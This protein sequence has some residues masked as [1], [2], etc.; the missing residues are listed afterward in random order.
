MD[1][2][3]PDTTPLDE[4]HASERDRL[5]DELRGRR[6]QRRVQQGDD[7][8]L[9]VQADLSKALP[10]PTPI[11]ADLMTRLLGV[12]GA[13]DIASRELGIPYVVHRDSVPEFTTVFGWTFTNVE[14]SCRRRASGP[15]SLSSFRLNRDVE[16]NTI[17]YTETYLPEW[18]ARMIERHA[19]DIEALPLD[20]AVETASN[21]INSF[22]S[23][24]AA[25]AER[26]RLLAN[27]QNLTVGKQLQK[28]GIEPCRVLAYER[29][30][31]EATANALLSR[32][33]VSPECTDQFMVLFG[34][35]APCDLELAQPRF[36]EDASLVEQYARQLQ[37]RT[38]PDE[39]TDAAG[40]FQ[41]GD[42]ILDYAVQRT[43]Y[44]ATLSADARHYSLFE[45]TL[46]RRLLLRIDNAAQLHGGA[47][48]LL[49]SEITDLA[50]SESVA[51]LREKAE[52]RMH[53]AS[54]W[55]DLRV[56]ASLSLNDIEQGCLSTP[57]NVSHIE[58]LRQKRFMAKD[59]RRMK[60][61]GADRRLK[62]RMSMDGT[63]DFGRRASDQSRNLSV[64]S[65]A[66]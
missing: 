53:I 4:L 45:L 9:L 37:S 30:S 44:L 54:Q 6:K 57:Q 46:I 47:F 56:P 63:P 60:T 22:V 51:V 61:T 12:D 42:D 35:R 59:R 58:E 25:H 21:W 18:Q 36:S 39:N 38:S 41:S 33:P 27:V 13:T 11:S 34:Q 29:D 14:E 62:T 23:D 16:S 17:A 15:D 65:K 50:N 40:C 19:I 20:Q 26:L 64:F 32:S 52:Q 48:Y 31:I 24:T 5:L 8:P 10:R 28:R 3:Q 49:I 7:S 55:S 1:D 43:R 66:G 2:G